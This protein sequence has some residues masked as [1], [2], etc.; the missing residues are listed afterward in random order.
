M[1]LWLMEHVAWLEM[2]GDRKEISMGKFGLCMI[3]LW[4]MWWV[5]TKMKMYGD[6]NKKVK[7]NECVYKNKEKNTHKNLS[8]HCAR[9]KLLK[10]KRSETKYL[11]LIENK[12]RPRIKGTL[13]ILG[14]L[15]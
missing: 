3:Q 11:G 8:W 10:R 2:F 15:Y 13:L 9:K 4:Y 5:R 14:A 1:I 6:V 12:L 7:E